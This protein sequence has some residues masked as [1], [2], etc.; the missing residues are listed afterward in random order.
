MTR[1]EVILQKVNFNRSSETKELKKYYYNGVSSW[2][3]YTVN[4]PQTRDL[5][6]Y[7]TKDKKDHLKIRH[8]ASSD[9]LKSE[10]QIAGAEA[11][12]GSIGSASILSDIINLLDTQ[13]SRKFLTLYEQGN[14][15][16]KSKLE[17]IGPKPKN[18]KQK[19]VYDAKRGEFSALY[20]TNNIFPSLIEWLEKGSKN[21][22]SDEFVRLLF[23]YITSRTIKSSKF[24]IA[25]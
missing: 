11:R 21:G 1:E 14:K 3:K 18:E 4:N 12:G 19:K 2:K 16:F 22:K 10:F 15:K 13:F 25:K 9:A 8:D 7:F 17:E 23:Q 6:I 20:I 5:K 24:I